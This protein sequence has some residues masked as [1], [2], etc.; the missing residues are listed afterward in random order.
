MRYQNISLKLPSALCSECRGPG[1]NSVPRLRHL[2]P[3]LRGLVTK[4]RHF[5]PLLRGLVTNLRCFVLLRRCLITKLR[6]LVMNLRYMIT[7]LRSLVTNL[8][9]FVPPAS[10]FGPRPVQLKTGQE[11]WNFQLCR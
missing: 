2:V 1:R 6:S 8:R 7:N 9:S 10:S 5:V 3:L 4:L 11:L